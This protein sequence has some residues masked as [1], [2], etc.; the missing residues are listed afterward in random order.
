MSYLVKNFQEK[1]AYIYQYIFCFNWSKTAVEELLQWIDTG[2]QTASI[3][4]GKKGK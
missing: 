1:P 3:L 4:S 2:S